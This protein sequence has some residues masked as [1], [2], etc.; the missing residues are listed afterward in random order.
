M[1]YIRAEVVP[2]ILDDFVDDPRVRDLIREQSLGLLWDALEVL[3]RGLAR[4]DDITE[5]ILRKLLLRPRAAD[6]VPADELPPRR[7]RSHAG[8]IT[9]S[10]G[11]GIDLALISLVAAQ[12][13]AIV[14]SLL[15]AVVDPIPKDVLAVITFGFALLGP[16]Y[17]AVAW[18]TSGRSIGGAIAGYAVVGQGDKPMGSGRA[19]V[20][21]L[22]SLLPRAAVGGRHARHRVPPAPPFVGRPPGGLADA[23][24]RPPRAVDHPRPV[25]VALSASG[26]AAPHRL[27]EWKLGR[28]ERGHVSTFGARSGLSIAPGSAQAR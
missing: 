13:L 5:G 27:Q 4:A 11:A 18:R 22:T 15:G 21:A 1:P 17:L 26:S 20:R 2:V 16:L 6:G 9:R 19:L 7:G 12:G 25:R 23:V 14:V 8:L 3:R 10:V 24:P 28:G